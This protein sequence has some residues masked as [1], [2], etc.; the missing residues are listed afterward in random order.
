M[1]LLPA[2]LFCSFFSTARA[3]DVYTPLLTQIAGEVQN[4][5]WSN[6]QC[7]P[8]L[9]AIQNRI[10]QVGSTNYTRAQFQPLAAGLIDQLW[11]IRLT[12]HDHLAGASD[13]C[14]KEIRNS[15]R[16]FRFIEDFLG[17]IEFAPT[18]FAD[19]DSVDFEKQ[20][21][22]FDETTNGYLVQKADPNFQFQTGDIIVA[23]GHS[24][25]SAMI[26][27][28]GDIDS[29]FSH[30]IMV[31]ENPQTKAMETIE[32]YVGLGVAIYDRQT[33][34]RNDNSRLLVL[35]PKDQALGRAAALQMRAVVAAR[36]G[37]NRIQY[38]YALD[39]VDHT[40]MSC[41]EVSQVAFLNASNG[42]FILP[43]RAS[44]LTHGLDLVERLGVKPGPTF[45]PG[46][47]EGDSRFDI[48]A[49]WRDL[50]T[51]R[52]SRLKDAIMTKVIAW[53]DADQFY[54]HD[55]VSSTMAR[56]LVWDIRHSFLWPTF[57][58]VFKTKDFS[59]EVPRAMVSTVE[60]VTEMG[61]AVLAELKARDDSHL[62]KTG[63][64]MTY[65]ELYS[66]LEDMRIEDEATYLGRKT[67]SQSYLFKYLRPWR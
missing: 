59:A 41:A 52:D 34:L 46:D 43:E 55:T 30:V 8:T 56:T 20:P 28:L 16:Q 4:S 54:L 11:K 29:Q 25:L 49:E 27:R 7:V 12:L 31:T 32:S 21:T 13:D 37:A 66:E 6:A 50:R 35:R 40:R 45:T 17:E 39:F 38:D 44:T 33:A 1:S 14:A 57:K 23:R 2:V 5:A 22:A 65:L 15:F 26:A 53:M 67:H 62:Q 18:E 61:D 51:T 9:Q 3:Q 19:L 24:F 47:L 63:L 10:D 60:L 58:K 48:V 42:K 36:T 64:P